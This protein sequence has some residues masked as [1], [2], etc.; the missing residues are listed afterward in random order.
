MAQAMPRAKKRARQKER[1]LVRIKC[2]RLNVR[3]RLRSVSECARLDA[4]TRARV[5]GSCRVCSAARNEATSRTVA[6]ALGPAPA[7]GGIRGAAPLTP[8]CEVP[9]QRVTGRSMWVRGGMA[10]EYVAEWRVGT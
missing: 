6:S 4:R 8:I 7:V 1:M 9:S 3:T 5:C 2:M 10:R